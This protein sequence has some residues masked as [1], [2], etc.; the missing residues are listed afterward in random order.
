MENAA[1]ASVEE[2]IE[3]INR[4]S[5]NVKLV[6]QLIKSPMAT[7]VNKTPTVESATPL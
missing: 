7:A 1:A 5:N 4:D 3:P 6:S 2:I